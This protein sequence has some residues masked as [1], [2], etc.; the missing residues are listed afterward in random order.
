MTP[1]SFSCR[2]HAGSI[3]VSRSGRA[4]VHHLARI[5]TLVAGLPL[6]IELAAAW[7]RALSLH[8]IADQIAQHLD[9]LAN[10]MRDRPER[11]RSIRAVF[12][13]AWQLLSDGERDAFRRLSVFRGSFR[14]Q[15]ASQVS[16]SSP[17]VLSALVDKSLL[18]RLPSGRYQL[19]ELLRQYG[20]E[21]LEQ[22]P[23]KEERTRD[24]HCQAYATQLGQYKQALKDSTH[25]PILV[26]IQKDAENVH[27]AW[28]WAIEQQN[29]GAIEAMHAALADY[30]HL[31]TSFREGEALFR[32]A[33]EDLGWVEGSEGQDLLPWK[34]HSSQAT[35]SVYL[36][37]FAQARASLDRCLAIFARQGAQDEM[38][39]CQFFLGEI[40]RFTGEFGS[41]RDLF[42]TS[43][44]GYRQVGN[45]SAMGFCLN[46]LGLV[47]AALGES[48]Q[49]R[50]YL[51]ESLDLFRETEHEM[52]QAIVGINLA[53]LLIS[54]TE[55]AAAKEILDQSTLLCEKLGH[56][57]GMA[58]CVRNLGDIA[59]L[60]RP[61][62]GSKGGL[63]GELADPAGH[64]ATTDGGRL[65]DQAGAGLYRPW[66][67]RGSQAASENGVDGHR[68]TPGSGADGWGRG[69]P[70]L[71]PGRRRRYREGPGACHA[72]RA[73][74][75]RGAGGTGTSQAARRPNLPSKSP[76][77]P[78]SSLR[79]GAVP[80][81]LRRCWRNLSSGWG[82]E[83]PSN[84]RGVGHP[85][86]TQ[87]SPRT[88]RTCACSPFVVT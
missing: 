66:R 40:A 75:R 36:G 56:R 62:Q 49:A 67:V 12:D 14:L 9:F 79:N 45:P 1:C 15:E 44:S 68:R 27:A 81:R 38:A 28:R 53:D 86:D 65:L 20:R 33:L 4:S 77:K 55:Y 13:H 26:L 64:R 3:S 31:T 6:A 50:V 70:G 46:G 74:S 58:T 22:I 29:T 16:G 34:L 84:Q 76:R 82:R 59:R 72:G 85:P 11:H 37:R 80:G 52:G 25:M 43:L 2:R 8:E 10:S 57:W 42:E 47:C 69:S 23:G 19:H 30:Y 63:P 51:Q 88:H 5:C 54:L 39:H 61:G 21:Q 83:A 18:Q 71:A 73:P 41:A 7:V 35:F 48:R 17:A 32:E 60:R 78:F 24:L 87:R